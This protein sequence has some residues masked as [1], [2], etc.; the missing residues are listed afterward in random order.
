MNDPLQDSGCIKIN[1][2]QFT[3]TTTINITMNWKRLMYSA[4][5]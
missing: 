5:N 3:Y 4:R 1:I 2:I